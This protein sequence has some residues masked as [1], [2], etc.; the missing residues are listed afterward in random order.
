MKDKLAQATE[1]FKMLLQESKMINH[2][3]MTSI[4]ESEQHLRDIIDI[5]KKDKRYHVLEP[6]A[7][8]RTEMIMSYLE[9]LEARGLPPPPTAT[10]PSR[11]KEMLDETPEIDLN[12]DWKD[13]KR[14]FKE[15]PRY[16][17][18]SSSERKCE[19]EFNEYMKDKLAQ[20]TEDFKMLLQESKIINHKSMTSVK[21]SEQHLRD[22]IDILKKDKRYHVLEPVAEERTEMIMS[23]LEELEARGPPPPPTAT[24]PSRRKEMLDETPEIDL[25]TD[26]KDAKRLIKE[27]P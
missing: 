17:K 14:L 13:A 3:S 15:D 4:K 1:D 26:W 9:E 10:E 18:F 16:L 7:E 19:K 24:E 11:R 21:E 25:N 23:F 8:E 12:T 20:A 6:V 27:D 5:L 22:I 2:K